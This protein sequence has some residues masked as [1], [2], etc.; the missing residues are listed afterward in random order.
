[1]PR[2]ARAHEKTKLREP[3]LVRAAMAAAHAGARGGWRLDVEDQWNFDLSGAVLKRGLLDTDALASCDELI[4][5]AEH[6]ASA[7]NQPDLLRTKL[8]AVHDLVTRL[9]GEPVPLCGHVDAFEAVR[10]RVDRLP[11]LLPPADASRARSEDRHRLAYDRHA[12]PDVV[13]VRGIRLLLVLDEGVGDDVVLV[14]RA[15]ASS[16]RCPACGA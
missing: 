9:C 13:S 1:M 3:D 11:Q 4:R 10:Y 7:M 12:R 16:N 6:R 2:R 8:P 15:K 14:R 5:M